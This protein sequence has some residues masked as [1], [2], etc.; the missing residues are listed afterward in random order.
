MKNF[1][2]GVIISAVLLAGFS[3]SA[4]SQPDS[5]VVKVVEKNRTTDLMK[6]S[7]FEVHFASGG[8][9]KFTYV[10]HKEK[11]CSNHSDASGCPHEEFPA[12]PSVMQ[13]FDFENSSNKTDVYRPENSICLVESKYMNCEGFSRIEILTVEF[14][15]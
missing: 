12:Q 3:A 1:G 6:G 2:Y 9:E 7:V 14:L 4:L 8:T 13:E 11:Y 5:E 15:D 10:T